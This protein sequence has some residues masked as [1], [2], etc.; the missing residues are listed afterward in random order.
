MYVLACFI[1][2]C[3]GQENR[4]NSI[5]KFKDEL[6]KAGGVVNNVVMLDKN[7]EKNTKADKPLTEK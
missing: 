7:T 4:I 2:R 5:E 1:I 3:D 6:C